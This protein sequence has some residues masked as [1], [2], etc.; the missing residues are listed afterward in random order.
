MSRRLKGL[1]SLR[2]SGG[3]RHAFKASA[4]S[5]SGYGLTTA[6]RFVS[7][8]VLAKM[9]N[10]SSPMGDV[11]IVSVILS[12]LEMISDLGIGVNI[13]QHRQGDDPE[14]LGTA[15]SCRC[16]AAALYGRSPPC[17]RCR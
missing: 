13:V 8:L 5:F 7:R 12:G 4:W 16:S 9:L 10:I 17:L 3:A 14:F 11:A 1:A 6:L 2:H 15:F